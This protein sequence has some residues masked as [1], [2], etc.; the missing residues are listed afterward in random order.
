MQAVKDTIQLNPAFPFR[1]YRIT[2]ERQAHL[3]DTFHWHN[4]FEIT[5]IESGQGTYYVNEK[6]F[7]VS[8]HD[9]VIFNNIEPHGWMI[10]KEIHALVLVFTMDFVSGLAEES[11]FELLKPFLER[12]SNF[13]NLINAQDLGAKEMKEIM[14]ELY[15]EWEMK[16]TGY[17]LMVKA[18]VLRLLTLLTRLYTDP[19]KSNSLLSVKKHAMLRLEKALEYMHTQYAEKITLED[20]AQ[21]CY[22]SPNYFSSY[23]KK[24]TGCNFRDYLT[25]IRVRH[26]QKLLK[27]TDWNA[28]EIALQC[29]FSNM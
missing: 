22:M 23:F 16:E 2:L 29:G 13:Q 25:G 1:I 21:L 18:D 10:E 7:H 17:Q 20:M 11:S 6:I 24:T 14:K 12:G 26:A 8:S 19:S 27:T 5:Y 4:Y 28:V 15:K 9:F 3:E